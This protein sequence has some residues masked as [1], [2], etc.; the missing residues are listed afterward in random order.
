MPPTVCEWLLFRHEMM[1]LSPLGQLHL[2]LISSLNPNRFQIQSDLIRL[3]PSTH[4]WPIIG[5][6]IASVVKLGRRVNSETDFPVPFLLN[7]A[8]DRA[9]DLGCHAGNPEGYDWSKNE[10]VIQG[11]KRM[12]LESKAK[13]KALGRSSML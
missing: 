11:L 12:D 9:V 8:F 6:G 13:K 10:E 4:D 5:L 2:L 3:M 1:L 7:F